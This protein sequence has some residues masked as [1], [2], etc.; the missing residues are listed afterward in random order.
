MWVEWCNRNVATLKVLLFL[1]CSLPLCVVYS[2]YLNDALGA[3]PLEF[4]TTIS[5]KSAIYCLILSLLITPLRKWM[6]F[7]A[8]SFYWRFGKR[9]ADWNWLVRLRRQLGLWCFSYALLHVLL[10]AAFDVLWDGRQFLQDIIVKPYLIFGAI[11]M[12]L[13][14]PL[15][16]T[17]PTYFLRRMGRKWITLHQTVYV[18]APLALLHIFMQSKADDFQ[19]M[20]ETLIITILLG[21]RGALRFGLIK[22][23]N[24]Y[25]GLETPVR[26]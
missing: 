5:G 22:Q 23:W 9:L 18:I 4:L 1:A 14:V 24:G 13:L 21:Y 19:Y 17:S 6:S 10:Y 20:P 7:L 11:T 3:N 25:D 16:L 12:L 15:A 2:M 8:V 26:Q